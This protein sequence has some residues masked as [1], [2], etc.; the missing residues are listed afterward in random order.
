MSLPEQQK[1]KLKKFI[2]DLSSH[3]GRHTS[4]VSVYVPEGY[5]INKIIQHLS[6]ESG[7]ATN[8]KDATTRKNVIDALEKMIQHLRLFKQT[9]PNGLAVF[10]GNVASH[11]GKQDFKVWSIEPPIPLKTRLYR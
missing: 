6:Q 11:E 1:H 5:E 3:K 8:I 7:T 9:P 2:K 4:L 10:S